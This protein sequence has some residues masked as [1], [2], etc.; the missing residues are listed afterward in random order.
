VLPR[1]VSVALWLLACAV[2]AGWLALVGLHV[3]DDY[4]IGHNQ[5]VW[6][7]VADAARNGRLYPPIF[8]GE[9][10]AGT[11]YMPGPILLNGFAAGLSDDPLVG[12]KLLAA[13]LMATLLAIVIFVLRRCSCPWPVAVT[14]AATIVA[15]D[16]GLQAGTSI[17]GDLLPTV[18]Q[19]GALAIALGRERRHLAIAGVLAGFGIASKLT[20][21][22][23]LAA[24]TTWLVMTRQRHTAVLFAAVCVGTASLSLG[25]VEVMSNGGL[26]QHLLAFSV[27]GVHGGGSLLRGPNQVLY[28]LLGHAWSTVVLFPI[29]AL[30]VLLP[31]RS[32]QISLLHIALAYALLLL[33]I[34]YADVGT[35]FNQLLDVV[36]LTVL[37]VGDLAG[38]ATS[39]D[40]PEAA[41]LSLAVLVSVVWAGGLDLVRTVGFDVRGAVAAATGG[42][43]ATR[44]AI[45]AAAIVKPQEAVLA[46][47]PAI[48]VA[49]RRQ[50]VVM[51]PFMV[52][53]LDRVRPQL[54]EPLIARISERRFDLVV[55]VVPLDDRSLDYWWNDFHYGPRVAAA[56]RDSY[57]ADGTLGRYFLYRPR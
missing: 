39:V 36:V 31:G 9:H 11:R 52:M 20:G 49:L 30:G 26:S 55:L 27:A 53:R 16:T 34:T 28:N 8:D 5:G 47:D 44:A 4:R 12:G 41:V 43:P 56:L 33:V 54:V 42:R 14:L 32:R 38:R 10:Y 19:T 46:E 1:P 51:D 24:V 37:A 40:R 57:R 22:W 29:A 48:Y 25:A 35:G 45:A 15:T 50:P 17:G 13:V 18:L 2:L 6:L 23:G 3:N 7:A 21:V